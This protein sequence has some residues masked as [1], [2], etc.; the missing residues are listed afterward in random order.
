MIA[1]ILKPV[2]RFLGKIVGTF[3]GVMVAISIAVKGGPPDRGGKADALI[4]PPV[5]R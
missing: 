4:R 2:A 5:L 1:K 3:F